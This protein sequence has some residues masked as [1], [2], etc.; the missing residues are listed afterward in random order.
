[1]QGKAAGKA[2]KAPAG[3]LRRKTDDDKA[4]ENGR[5]GPGKADEQLFRGYQQDLRLVSV[6]LAE[7]HQS[8]LLSDRRDYLFGVPKPPA[9][10]LRHS[11]CYGFGAHSVENRR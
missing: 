1:M 9:F 7:D 4:G 3:C 5:H 11:S 10:A 6:D 8:G 2:E